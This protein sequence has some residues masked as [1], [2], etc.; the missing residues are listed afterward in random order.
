VDQAR[1]AFAQAAALTCN[2]R[3]RDLLLERS[4][5]CSPD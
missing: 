4:A 1:A 5:R 3:E 2:A